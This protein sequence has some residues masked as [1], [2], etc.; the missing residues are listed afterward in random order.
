MI[1]GLSESSI[2]RLMEEGRFPRPIILSRNRHGRPVRIAWIESEVRGWIAA[3]I[4]AERGPGPA[5]TSAVV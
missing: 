1:G 3:R 4:A 5:V 2:R